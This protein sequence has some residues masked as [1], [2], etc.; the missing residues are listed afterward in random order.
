MFTTLQPPGVE[1]GVWCAPRESAREFSE[2]IAPAGSVA[3]SSIASAKPVAIAARTLG[4]TVD[5]TSPVVW[6]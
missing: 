3:I 6:K 5:G 4:P 2:R 1:F